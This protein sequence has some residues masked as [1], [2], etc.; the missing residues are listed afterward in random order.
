[1][2]LE[3]IDNDINIL[4]SQIDLYEKHGWTEIASG[5]KDNLIMLLAKRQNFL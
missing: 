3:Q 5:Y 1:M 4:K 2:T